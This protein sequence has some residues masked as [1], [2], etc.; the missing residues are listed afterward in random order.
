MLI[1]IS[2]RLTQQMF[3]LERTYRFFR[4]TNRIEIRLTEI[5]KDSFHVWSTLIFFQKSTSHSFFVK[6]S[7]VNFSLPRT[8][9]K[10]HAFNASCSVSTF[11]DG[12]SW[13]LERVKS[14]LAMQTQNSP[15]RQANIL[16]T[17]FQSNFL[18]FCNKSQLSNIVFRSSKEKVNTLSKTG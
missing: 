8:P 15:E 6:V 11:K 14:F 16:Q 13:K 9:F 5:N 18:Y 2:D 4:S 7:V 12:S 17:M 10:V 3:S 1:F